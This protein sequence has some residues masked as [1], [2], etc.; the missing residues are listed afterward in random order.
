MN[1]WAI[2]LFGEVTIVQGIMWLASLAAL[3]FILAKAWP[4]LKR[5]VR[6][7]DAL[8]ALPTFMDDT[9]QKIDSIHHETHTNNGSS[10]KDAQRRTEA[11]VDRIELGTKAIYDQL[12]ELVAEDAAIRA[13]IE[14]TR[15]KP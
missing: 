13:D 1:D 4:W 14:T 15:P 12:A 9:K 10:I 11:A 5:A 8:G 6:L 3:V 7:V 2:T